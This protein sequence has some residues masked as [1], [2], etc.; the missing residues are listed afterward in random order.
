MYSGHFKYCFAGPAQPVRP[1]LLLFQKIWSIMT[2]FRAYIF[3]SLLRTTT[4][5]CNCIDLLLF[6][7]EQISDFLSLLQ[8]VTLVGFFFLVLLR[9][10][11]QRRRFKV[12]G[13]KD[14]PE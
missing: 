10:S 6:L 3:C 4:V 14:R 11:I 13:I 5:L 8:L 12:S 7:Q 9:V 1:S 2:I